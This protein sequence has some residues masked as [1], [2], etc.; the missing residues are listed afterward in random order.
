MVL[1]TLLLF[2]TALFFIIKSSEH[3]MKSLLRIAEHF[4]ISEFAAGFGILAVATS[5]PELF[6]GIIASFRGQP[7]L[8]IG[9]V[10]GSNI[11]DVALVLG[12]AAVVVNG[13]SFS[14]GS[15]KEELFYVL[16]IAVLPLIMMGDGVLSRSDGFALVIVFCFYM[17]NIF[18][19][20][21]KKSKKI[22][23]TESKEV[24]LNI[25]LF[26]ASIATL[27]VSSH[28]LVTYAVEL[29][30]E[31]FLPLLLVGLFFVSVGTSV[32]ELVVE[33]RAALTKHDEIAVGGITGSVVTNASLVLGISALIAP[34][35]Q[36]TLLYLV[37]TGFM[38]ASLATLMIITAISGKITRTSALFLLL[39]YCLF[40]AS[41]FY[42]S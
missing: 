26:S 37:S 7:D 22:K 6:V 16:G 32:P 9:T 42:L 38:V 13:I 23:R 31:L 33:L 4:N 30:V 29:S 8:I 10:I 21:R 20:K 19:Q 2:C 39:I 11:A 25:A 35:H 40:I 14:K 1:I 12:I 18:G 36:D 34:I 27:F 17:W 24:F 15:T 3:A 28:F 41:E 5:L